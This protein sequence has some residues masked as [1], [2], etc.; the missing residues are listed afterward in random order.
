[1]TNTRQR[2]FGAGGGASSSVESALAN[3]EFF[4][5]FCI[6]RGQPAV[7]GQDGT[8]EELFPRERQ[9]APVEKGGCV[10]FKDLNWTLALTI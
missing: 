1:M 5:L 6:A 10:D 4:R 3:R 8:V 7:D 2:F 9:L